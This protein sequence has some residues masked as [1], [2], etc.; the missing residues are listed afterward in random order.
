MTIALQNFALYQ[1]EDSKLYDLT[2]M[3]TV[4][5]HK[6]WGY[7]N[8][9]HL[10]V[11]FVINNKLVSIKTTFLPFDNNWYKISHATFLRILPLTLSAY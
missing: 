3:L 9:S 11:W 5:F 2:L 10:F 7:N 1:Q 4:Q 6:L 8:C